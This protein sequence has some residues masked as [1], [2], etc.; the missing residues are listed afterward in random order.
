MAHLEGKDFG[1]GNENGKRSCTS[2]KSRRKSITVDEM[3]ISFAAIM[4]GASTMHVGQ[5]VNS[6]GGGSRGGQNDLSKPCGQMPAEMQINLKGSDTSKEKRRKKSLFVAAEI[7]TSVFEARSGENAT[8][9][10]RMIARQQKEH[11]KE[12]RREVQKKAANEARRRSQMLQHLYK[13]RSRKISMDFITAEKIAIERTE[14]VQEQDRFQ[15]SKLK[16]EQER[17]KLLRR[18]AEETAKRLRDER[19][20]MKES[21]KEMTKLEVQKRRDEIQQTI[22]Q[23]GRKRSEEEDKIISE[24]MDEMRDVLKTENESMN[25]KEETRLKDNFKRSL[26]NQWSSITDNERQAVFD[27]AVDLEEELHKEEGKTFCR[28]ETSA[29]YANY[30]DEVSYKRPI[31]TESIPR[32]YSGDTVDLVEDTT[33]IV[34]GNREDTHAGGAVDHEDGN[35]AICDSPVEEVCASQESKMEESKVEE[36]KVGETKEIDSENQVTSILQPLS[37]CFETTVIEEDGP[38]LEDDVGIASEEDDNLDRCQSQPSQSPTFIHPRSLPSLSP[39]VPCEGTG[40]SPLE[41]TTPTVTPQTTLCTALHKELED[42]DEF[43]PPEVTLPPT[44]PSIPEDHIWE[45][46]KNE[47]DANNSEV[48]ESVVAQASSPPPPVGYYR[49]QIVRDGNFW[50]FES[51]FLGDTHDNF[52]WDDFP[53]SLSAKSASTAET[54]TCPTVEGGDSTRKLNQELMDVKFKKRISIRHSEAASI[55]DN[56]FCVR[57]AHP[58]SHLRKLMSLKS[59]SQG[60]LAKI[61][62]IIEQGQ[63]MAIS[64]ALECIFLESAPHSGEMNDIYLGKMDAMCKK[65]R[66]LI[67]LEHQFNQVQVVA[68]CSTNN[69]NSGEKRS[70][71]PETDEQNIVT[72]CFRTK[73]KPLVHNK[74]MNTPELHAA[75]DEMM[76]L[77]SASLPRRSKGDRKKRVPQKKMPEIYVPRV[78]AKKSSSTP[79]TVNLDENATALPEISSTRVNNQ[80]SNS[81]EHGSKRGHTQH[82][83]LDREFPRNSNLQKTGPP[84]SNGRMRSDSAPQ[85][86]GALN[87]E[88][89]QSIGILRGPKIAMMDG[90]LHSPINSRHFEVRAPRTKGFS[91]RRLRTCPKIRRQRERDVNNNLQMIRFSP[92]TAKESRNAEDHEEDVT[93]VTADVRSATEDGMEVMKGNV[94]R[95]SSP[96]QKS[97]NMELSSGGKNLVSEFDDMINR[98]KQNVKLGAVR[99]ALKVESTSRKAKMKRRKDFPGIPYTD[100]V[101]PHSLLGLI[102]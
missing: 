23:R 92:E 5:D 41:V 6:N 55:N 31:S 61:R 57:H 2:E 97:P 20:T 11:D 46:C 94:Q 78:E 43:L 45:E 39:V 33:C 37:E 51:P 102:Q 21:I 81:V 18:E 98:H 14:I 95:S 12:T 60:D 47:G 29:K 63:C 73:A 34:D 66:L 30:M 26:E 22:A 25:E 93:G 16:E 67:D 87:V 76:W 72:A 13:I 32:T 75:V 100:H 40:R 80:I 36:T 35:M 28:E 56:K 10:A 86:S 42:A 88:A 68:P 17:A 101:C 8:A 44:I 1:G 53:A 83:Q 9:S 19:A 59:R 48:E 82:H 7:A 54:A 38:L 15:E 3:P 74:K 96:A 84:F 24:W 64:E 90:A 91:A 77:P 27:L 58:S 70:H 71:R 4:D 85:E 99:P 52:E 50:R 69:M 49:L 62:T 79:I 89:G 65:R